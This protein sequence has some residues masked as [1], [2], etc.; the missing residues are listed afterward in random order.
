MGLLFRA[1][2]A[3]A[4]FGACIAPCRAQYVAADSTSKKAYKPSEPQSSFFDKVNFGGN[5]SLRFSEET[6]IE[7][8]PLAIYNV[9][10]RLQV[11]PGITYIYY[12][13]KYSN[14]NYSS[15]QYG[16]RLFGRYTVLDNIF[17]QAELEILNLGVRNQDENGRF[18]VVNPLVGGGYS[19]ALGER[20]S[21]FVTVLYN[22]D[23]IESRSTYGSPFVFRVGFSL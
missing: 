10:E 17:T 6:L 19:Q 15:S 3:F 7:V 12:R 1:F 23:Y 8:S 2:C 16:G 13:A 21:V 20:G 11:G 5:F 14:F 9:N 18:T 4:L 22:L